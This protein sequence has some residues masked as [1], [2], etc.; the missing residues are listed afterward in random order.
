MQELDTHLL[1][2]WY[3]GMFKHTGIE[4]DDCRQMQSS[5]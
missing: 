2:S 1:Q 3:E 4:P 5:L